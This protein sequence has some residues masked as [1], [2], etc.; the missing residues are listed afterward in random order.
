MKIKRIIG[1]HGAN[2]EEQWEMNRLVGL[3]RVTP[4][5]SSVY[6]M[7]EIGEAARLVQTNAHMGKVGVLCLA[8][9]AGLGVTDH[10]QRARVGMD[11]P[12][13]EG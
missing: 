9:K 6:P 4:L 8:P 12:A 13:V 5:V 11:Q 7:E 3:G 2:I 1:S 10:E